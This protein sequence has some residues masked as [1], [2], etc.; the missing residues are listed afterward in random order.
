VLE[1][2]LALFRKI[3]S[4]ETWRQ[5]TLLRSTFSWAGMN[6]S[7]SWQVLFRKIEIIAGVMCARGQRHHFHW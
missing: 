7:R 4:L 3:T 6:G 1:E 5:A 2:K